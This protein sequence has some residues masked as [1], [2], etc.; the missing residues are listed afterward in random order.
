MKSSALAIIALG[1]NLGEPRRNV[2]CAMERLRD[3]SD[4]PLLKSSLWQTTPVNSPPDS[5]VFVNTVVGLAPRAGETPESLLAKLQALEKEF[6]RTPKKVQNESRP[7]DLDLIAFRD[8]IHERLRVAP[9]PAAGPRHEA[10]QRLDHRRSKKD[11]EL[12]NRDM[13]REQLRGRGPLIVRTS[14][15]K[16]YRVAHPE[17]VLI[18]RYNVVIE[19]RKGY[20]TFLIPFISSRFVPRAAKDKKSL[21]DRFKPPKQPRWRG[22]VASSPAGGKRGTGTERPRR[23]HRMARGTT[24]GT[25]PLAHF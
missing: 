2:L 8:P 22:Q 7:L 23:P 21:P 19:Q 5:P 16:Q 25:Q 15:G 24:C 1:S 20:S 14:D 3:L 9:K 10:R 6:G 11:I 17:F 18:G 12:V 4:R 13:I